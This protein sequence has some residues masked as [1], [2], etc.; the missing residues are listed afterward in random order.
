MAAQTGPRSVI[1]A[2]GVYVDPPVKG[3]TTIH[4]G[5]LVVTENGLAI[6]GKTGVGLTALGVAETSVVNKGGD[7]AARALVKRGTFAFFTLP[8]DPVTIAD[9]GKDCFIVD[10]QTVAKTSGKDTRSVAGKVMSIDADG[11]FVRVGS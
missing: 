5:A 4:Q 9:L 11:I 1:E 3:N 6:P 2:A 7:G 10:D 8:A